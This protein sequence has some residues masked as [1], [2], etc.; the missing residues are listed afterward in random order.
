MADPIIGDNKHIDV[1]GT[2]P[3]KVQAYSIVIDKPLVLRGGDI[4]LIARFVSFEG[5]GSIDVDGTDGES[6]GTARPI[7][8]QF[9]AGNTGETG[10]IGGAGGNIRIICER[11]VGNVSLRS[12]GGHGGPGQNGSNGTQGPRGADRRD[13]PGDRGGQ[14]F[15]AG[16]GGAGGPG[17]PGGSITIRCADATG[18]TLSTSVDGGAGGEIGQH[19]LPGGGGP[20]GSGEY[21]HSGGG[22]GSDPVC[23]DRG[24]GGW[25]PVGTI[26]PD[27]AKGNPGT[28]GSVI[29]TTNMNPTE[30][31]RAVSVAA[32]DRYS[33]FLLDV[34]EQQY[35]D[36]NFEDAANRIQWILNTTV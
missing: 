18:A 9:A 31:Y 5:T 20:P 29:A 25:G 19:G 34:S 2:S 10:N 8:V 11:L 4:E 23:G 27:Q 15:P 35:Y 7:T 12:V 17:G 1:V 28:A 32:S 33:A 6:K 16:G 22:H 13:R 36:S 3:F 21:C 30:L 26:P 14:G 24:N